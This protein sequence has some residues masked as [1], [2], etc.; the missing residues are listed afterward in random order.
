MQH[1]KSLTRKVSLF[2]VLGIQLVALV[3]TVL[4]GSLGGSSRGVMVSTSAHACRIA[5]ADGSSV[6]MIR[7][8][9]RNCSKLLGES[10]LDIDFD[11]SSLRLLFDGDIRLDAV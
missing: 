1:N 3:G 4:L 7:E 9:F 2:T 6:D 8:S 10:L 11:A 5:L